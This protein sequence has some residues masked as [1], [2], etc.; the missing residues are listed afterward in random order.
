DDCK[1]SA[2]QSL[3]EIYGYGKE[4]DTEGKE[5]GKEKENDREKKEEYNM[6][7]IEL[8]DTVKKSC[9]SKK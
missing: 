1:I 9:D 5:N 7:Q 2:L 3:L 8:F 6:N 4:Y